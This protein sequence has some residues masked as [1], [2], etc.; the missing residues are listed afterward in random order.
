MALGE[1]TTFRAVGAIPVDI[2]SATVN[3]VT[4]PANQGEDGAHLTPRL[5][6]MAQVFR[7][8]CLAKCS[9]PGPTPAVTT[10]A[11]H[12]VNTKM[13]IL[14]DST[15]DSEVLALSRGTVDKMFSDY[16]DSRGEFPSPEIE[17]TEI[18]SQQ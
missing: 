18:S 15:I 8:A 1:P 7:N 11:V 3:E 6:G 10:P 4:V 5:K 14:V 16:R 2:Y 13:S 17:P 12:K 9:T